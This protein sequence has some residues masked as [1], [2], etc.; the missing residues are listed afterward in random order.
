MNTKDGSNVVKAVY[1]R[2]LDPGATTTEDQWKLINYNKD[3]ANQNGFAA[4]VV[5]ITEFQIDNDWV[6]VIRK[7]HQ[8]EK[9]YDPHKVLH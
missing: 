4:V 9:K 3:H 6:K 5:R 7:N 1:S 2:K 8:P